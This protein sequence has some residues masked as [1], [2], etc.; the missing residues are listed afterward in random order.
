MIEGN[1][2][3]DTSSSDNSDAHN[4]ADTSPCCASCGIPEV[5][6]I[7][8]KE[9]ADC[10]LVRYCSVECQKNHKSQ[11]EEDCKKRAAELR[12]ELLFKQPESN[13]LGDCPICMIPLSLDTKKSNMHNC[14][15]KVVVIVSTRYERRRHHCKNNVHSVENRCQQQRK[16]VINEG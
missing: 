14:C 10:D 3:A 8:L 13:H 6:D 15:S 5:D 2:Q 9:C 12:D 16:K 7:K 1:N 11:H 4:V